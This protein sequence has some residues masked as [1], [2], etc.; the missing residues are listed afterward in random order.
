MEF[1]PHNFVLNCI[2]SSVVHCCFL[3][4]QSVLYSVKYRAFYWCI[5]WP[6]SEPKLQRYL[7]NNTG[8]NELFPNFVLNL[9]TCASFPHPGN[10]ITS[11][12]KSHMGLD[13]KSSEVFLSLPWLHSKA[14][15][16]FLSGID[17]ISFSS[18]LSC[19]LPVSFYTNQLFSLISSTVL[20]QTTKCP[21]EIS[22]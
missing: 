2:T 3:N 22:Y 8:K 7:G 18:P 17:A 21:R 5:L 20:D 15:I 1:L 14:Q 9:I 10:Y 19:I 4:L 16:W 13:G 12:S 11:C 6:L